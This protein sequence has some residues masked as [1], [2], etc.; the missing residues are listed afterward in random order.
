VCFRVPKDLVPATVPAGVFLDA[1]VTEAG[2][3]FLTFG[4]FVQL[5]ALVDVRARM[6]GAGG[7]SDES[8]ITGMDVREAIPPRAAPRSAS[9]E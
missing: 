5:V 1:S 3:G 6:E 4:T 2:C 9:E 7:T 8:A